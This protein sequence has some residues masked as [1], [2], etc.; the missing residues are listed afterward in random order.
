[1]KRAKKIS[2]WYFIILDKDVFQ[3]SYSL[4]DADIND[5]IVGKVN[6]GE[7]QV[8]MDMLIQRKK[9]IIIQDESLDIFRYRR[10]WLQVIISKVE[11]SEIR[12][13]AERFEGLFGVFEVVSREI[14]FNLREVRNE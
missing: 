4:K 10:D 13:H 8:V 14:E 9:G 5:K 1:M 12:E 11:F 3:C 7:F 6:S 2:K